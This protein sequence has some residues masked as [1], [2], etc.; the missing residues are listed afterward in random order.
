[1]AQNNSVK[2]HRTT[3]RI[4]TLLS[5]LSQYENGLTF[6]ELQ[7]LIDIPKGTLSPILH[8]MEHMRF[9]AHS[10]ATGRYRIGINAY[11]VGIT[12]GNS[13]AELQFITDEMQRVVN[14]CRETC[15]LGILQ[16]SDVI[17]VAK[18]DSPLPIRLFS[19]V[20]KVF[21]AYCTAIGKAILSGFDRAD[22]KELLPAT[23]PA[24][25]PH[26]LKNIDELYEQLED[27]RHTGFARDFEEITEG[28]TCIAVP[29]HINGAIKYGMSVTTPSYRLDEK[30]QLLIESLLKSAQNHIEQA[31]VQFASSSI[32]PQSKINRP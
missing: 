31:Q 7:Q 21:P 22:I 6:T 3:Y 8:T 18:V 13:N 2:L 32:L 17:Y 19:D 28:I 29:V 16:G 11:L 1:M 14:A 20:G 12:Y 25:T 10:S 30:K 27:V 4:L 23:F 9:I 26:T 15:Q 5:K 24:H